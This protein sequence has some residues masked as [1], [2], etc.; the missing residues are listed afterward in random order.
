MLSDPA[1]F[2]PVPAM[3]CTWSRAASATTTRRRVCRCASASTG[4]KCN[5]PCARSETRNVGRLKPGSVTGS[6]AA[7]SAHF[8]RSAKKAGALRHGRSHARSRWIWLVAAILVV[9]LALRA[10]SQAARFLELP[11]AAPVKADLIVALGG[12]GGDRSL[13]A[14]SLYAA[15][16]APR[17]LLTGLE[18]SAKETRPAFLHWRAQVMHDRGVPMDRFEYDPQA[19]NSWE[20]AINTRRLM[21]A[22]RWKRVL[23]VS[24]PY[25][26]R[27]L[28][29]TWK[30][31]FKGS[32]LEFLPVATK[33]VFWKPDGWWRDEK[34][35]AQVI[36]EYI[37][38]GYYLVKY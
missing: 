10:I 28:S 4:C 20:E 15:G 33:P 14:A 7:G 1:F 29:W 2:W 34:S 25:H 24:D 5:A 11:G 6:Q 38:I 19:G 13:T 26:M 17:I 18:F 32:G 9:A 8:A 12:E 23:V 3:R 22:R 16:Y 27:R 21:E 36:M 35:G 30:Q 37:K 31:V